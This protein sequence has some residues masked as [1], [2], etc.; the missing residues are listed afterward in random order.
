M[1]LV[2]VPKLLLALS[3]PSAEVNQCLQSLL[4]TQF[5]HMLDAP[6]LAL[7]MPILQQA[8][9]LRSSESKKMAAQIIGNMYS[10]TEQKDL[11]PYMIGVL[12]GLKEALV[13]P[14]PEVRGSAA[15]ALGAMVKG[16]GEEAITDL[17]PWLFSMLQSEGSSVD[18]SGAAQGLAEVI[19][20]QGKEHLHAVMPKF[21]E[22]AMNTGASPQVRDGYLLLFVYLPLSFGEDFTSY[23]GTVLPCILQVSIHSQC[24]CNLHPISVSDAGFGR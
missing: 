22:A 9:S 8:L 20:A 4:D 15:R 2:L 11:S 6:S 21:V 19:R 18:R 12:P 1:Y 13:D 23:I 10:L 3:D 5:V 14:V 24:N 7:I 16:L 17:L